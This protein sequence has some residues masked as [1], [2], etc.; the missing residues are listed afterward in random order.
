MRIDVFSIFP[1]IVDAFCSESL[2]GKARESN[3]L[4]LRTHDLAG[5]LTMARVMGSVDGL[6]GGDALRRAL[7]VMDGV[8]G[9]IG[10]LRPGRPG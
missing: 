3:L 10:R 4:D 9:L 1:G 8:G 6:P 2:L 5:L 7:V